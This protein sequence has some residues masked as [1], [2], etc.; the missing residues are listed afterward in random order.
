MD[1]SINMR[2]ARQMIAS[3]SGTP[4]SVDERCVLSIKL[5]ELMLGEAHSSLTASEKKS[6]EQL[7]RLMSDPVGKAF[8][9]AMTD[10]CFRSKRSAR[11]ADQL[12]YLLRKYG[13]PR[14]LSFAKQMQLIAFE[15]LGKVFPGLLVPLARQMIRKE[16]SSVILPGESE[17]LTHHMLQRQKAGVRINLNHLGEAILGEEEANRRLQL[18]LDDLAKPEVEYVSIK[19]STL[20][21]QLNLLAWQETLSILSDR[22][23]QLYRTAASHRFMR[24]DGMAVPKFVNLDMEEYR[25]LMLTFTLFKTVLDDSEFLTHSA[26]IVLQSYLPDSYLIQQELTAWAKRR[27]D[28]GGAPIKLRIVKGANLAMERVEASLRGWSQAP[29]TTKAEVDANFK[30]MVEF[31]C[32]PENAKAVHLGIGSHNLFDIA[33][34]LFLR[35]EYNIEKQVSFEMLE[36]MADHMRRVVQQLSGEIL[37]YCPVAT[38]SEFQNAV[39]YLI[40]R[41]DENTAPENFLHD[42]FSIKPGIALWDKQVKLFTDACQ[43]M[44]S[45]DSLPR[46]QQNRFHDFA[47]LSACAS[48]ANEPDTDWSLPINRIWAKK[49]ID[50]EEARREKSLT[51]PSPLLDAS[52][53]DGVL[54]IAAK[55]SV[56]WA[57]TPVI[58]RAECLARMAHALRVHRGDLIGVMMAETNKTIPEAD[59]EV[60]EAVD[61][62]EYYRR[63]ILEINTLQDINWHP[64]GTVLVAP[65]WNF[66]CSIPAGG[67]LAALAAGNCVIFKPAP[68]AIHVGWTL[69]QALWESGISRDVLQ[70]VTC[71]DDPVGSQLIQDSRVNCVILTGATSTAKQ[72]MKM[73]PGIDLIAETGGKNAMIITSLADRDLA[74]KDAVQSAFGHAGQ[75]CSACSLLICEAEVYDDPHFLAQLQD[76]AASWCVGSAWNVATRLPPLIHAPNELLLKGLTTLE[77]GES[78]LLQP[79]KSLEHDNLWSPGIKL[80]VKAGSFMHQTELFGPILSVMR[81]D[82]L[83]H[84]IALANG[85][86]YGLTSGLHSLDQREQQYWSDHIE[87]GNCYIN[88]GITGAIVQ[89]QPFGG[90]KE[91]SFGLGSKTGGPNYLMQLM[92]AQQRAL[93]AEEAPPTTAIIAMTDYLEQVGCASDQLALWHASVGSYAFYW[94]NYFSLKQDPSRILGQDNFLYYVPHRHLVVRMQ[95]HDSIFDTMRVMS[96]A[97]LSGTQIE[98]S[99]QRPLL[100]DLSTQEW[101]ELI[102]NIKIVKESEARLLARLNSGKIKRLRFLSEP[103]PEL[104]IAIAQTE[105]NVYV[106]PVQANGRLELLHHL[107]EVALS[108]DY[109]RY[110]NLGDREREVREALQPKTA[111]ACGPCGCQ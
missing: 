87:S 34:A 24:A 81:A 61:F 46:R 85:T 99:A 106:A 79:K 76:A 41:L 33:Y 16:T 36:G 7:M 93:P 28:Q 68:E 107:R 71:E 67:I 20:C 111:C 73:R 103:L 53:V 96:A 1:E 80:G 57:G 29:Y 104:T 45:I 30:R 8:T 89:R 62:A 95:P 83:D 65:P 9:T 26:G 22:L 27:M 58:E 17:A 23:K 39:A 72:F 109:H 60:S 88:R 54:K 55:A 21:S 6:Q 102:P 92:R 64:K 19:I 5:V 4:M 70:F 37:L 78:W 101:L 11:V 91:S 31:G 74:I 15:I 56:D 13:V 48:F 86:P 69:I 50:T 3:V 52:Q 14:F 42:A 44:N 100:K 66:P 32:L 12:V 97:S 82:N 110:G 43:N 25:D 98:I 40:R 59:V 77:E 38:K 63:N 49:I 108:V 10:Q 18:Y 47:D 51:I 75:K 94:I 105:R 84:S 35:S 90:C 2:N